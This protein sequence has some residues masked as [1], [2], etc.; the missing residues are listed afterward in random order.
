MSYYVRVKYNNILF[1]GLVDCGATICA[2]TPE[3]ARQLGL[4]VTHQVNGYVQ[5]IGRTK[6]LG[7][8]K[9]CNLIINNMKVIVNFIVVDNAN[10]KLVILGQDFLEKYNCIINCPDK[11]LMVNNKTVPI[12]PLNTIKTAKPKTQKPKP[13]VKKVAKK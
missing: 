12:V 4:I 3:M 10:K 6:I 1:K 11:K 7:E 5:G 8:V 13:A 2:I 9:N